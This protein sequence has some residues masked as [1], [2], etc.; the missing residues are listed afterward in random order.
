[1][2]APVPTLI[3]MSQSWHPL[4]AI[5]SRNLFYSESSMLNLAHQ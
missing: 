5:V 1:M 3:F 4:E 2:K